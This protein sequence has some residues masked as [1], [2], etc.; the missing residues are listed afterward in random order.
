MGRPSTCKV[1]H[2]S[3]TAAT[4]YDGRWLQCDDL[5]IKPTQIHLQLYNRYALFYSQALFLNFTCIHFCHKL[6]LFMLVLV[7]LTIWYFFLYH[8]TLNYLYLII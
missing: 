7:Y 3:F 8:Y 2:G 1:Q 4:E 6:L 5:V